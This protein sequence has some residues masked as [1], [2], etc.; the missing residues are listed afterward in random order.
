MFIEHG[1]QV[2]EFVDRSFEGLRAYLEQ[3][4]VEGLVFTH[5]DGRMAKIRRKDF[6]FFWVKE[7]TRKR[8]RV[9]RP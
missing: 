3:N 2:V 4:Y 5:P 9:K 8:K 6:K 7:D 1:G